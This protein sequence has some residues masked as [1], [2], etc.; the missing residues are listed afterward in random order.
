MPVTVQSD[1]GPDHTPH[2]AG[3]AWAVKLNKIT[4][5][6]GRKAVEAQAANG[7]KKMLAG[8]TVDS[9]VTIYRDGQ[10]VGWLSSGG[11]GYTV[12]KSI[13]YGYVRHTDGVTADFILAGC[14]ELE[15][16]A[17]RVPATVHMKPLVDPEMLRVYGRTI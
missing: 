9:N 16:A 5:F 11:Y 15:V 17:E 14:Y 1:I 6:K 10:R 13:G 4:E 12:D 3:L 8:F 2:E 7:V